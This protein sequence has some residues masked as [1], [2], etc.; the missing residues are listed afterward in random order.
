MDTCVVC[1]GYVVEGSQVC[2][3]CMDRY[4][5][6]E[7][8]TLDEAYRFRLIREEAVK[9]FNGEVSAER[10]AEKVYGLLNRREGGVFGDGIC[11]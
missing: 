8:L 11:C 6:T 3:K 5:L 1:G 10:F 7:T 9:W 2:K 4:G